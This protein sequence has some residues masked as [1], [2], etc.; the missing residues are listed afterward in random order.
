[1]MIAQ[2]AI[3]SARLAKVLARLMIKRLALIVR[4]RV[5][6]MTLRA[7]PNTENTMRITK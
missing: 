3:P 2:Y 1:M 7:N 5:G 4:A 6:S